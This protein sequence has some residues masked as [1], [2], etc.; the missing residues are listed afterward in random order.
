MPAPVVGPGRHRGVDPHRPPAL[1]D[2]VRPGRAAPSAAASP[3]D[4]ILRPPLALFAGAAYEEVL[5]SEPVRRFS[6][7]LQE[8]ARRRHGC[9]RHSA[10]ST[11]WHP[12]APRSIRRSRS[13]R[14]RKPPFGRPRQPRGKR[15]CS[16]RRTVMSCEAG[17]AVRQ[18][19]L[20][21]YNV[22]S[23]AAARNKGRTGGDLSGPTCGLL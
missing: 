18:V 15:L 9:G 21:L 14:A 16:M 19:E 6:M 7:N 5:R 1:V 11:P 3:A 10:P 22:G 17:A 20:P 23:T 2:H 4:G 13:S 12:L 8:V